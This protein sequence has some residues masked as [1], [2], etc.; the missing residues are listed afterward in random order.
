MLNYGR[1]ELLDFGFCI[2]IAVLIV[3]VNESL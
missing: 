2:F 3:L 1:S